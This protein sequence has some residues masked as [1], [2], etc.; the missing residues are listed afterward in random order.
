MLSIDLEKGYITNK[1]KDIILK[2][3]PLH[4]IMRDILSEEGY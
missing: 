3:H 1:L 2:I 4:K